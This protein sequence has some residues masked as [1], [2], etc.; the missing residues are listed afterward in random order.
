MNFYIQSHS[1]DE[2]DKNESIEFPRKY[3][4]GCMPYY[5]YGDYVYINN[6]N[7]APEEHHIQSILKKIRYLYNIIV[8]VNGLIIEIFA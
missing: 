7:D 3:Y 2:N 4:I 5:N 6:K 8:K 1:T